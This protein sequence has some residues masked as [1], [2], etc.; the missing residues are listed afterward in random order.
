MLEWF[1][2]GVQEEA[3]GDA[4]VLSGYALEAPAAGLE[5]APVEDGWADRWREF[6]RPVRV[7]RLWIGPPW[8]P[9]EAEPVVIDPGHAFGTGAHGSTRAALGAPAATRAAARARSRLRLGRPRD[10][11]PAARLRAA[12]SPA[13]S[14]RWRWRPAQRTRSRNGVSL[15][16][17]RADALADPLPEAPLW[18]AN[19]QRDLLE[20]LLERRRPAAPDPG[21]GPARARERGRGRAGG[22]RRLGG[23]AGAAVSRQ[24]YRFFAAGLDGRGRR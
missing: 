5:E 22:R 13:T 1:P 8:Y 20:R 7:G 12:R 18:I 11:R 6:H 21:L 3:E 2:D 10:R 16:V 17:S 15:Q 9:P 23:G 4:V 19:L 24:R 14:I